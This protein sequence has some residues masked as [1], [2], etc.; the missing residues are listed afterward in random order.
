MRAFY[1]EFREHA[2]D[3]AVKD[4]DE[5]N[6]FCEEKRLTRKHGNVEFVTS[7]KYIH[8]Y[9]EE[10]SKDAKILILPFLIPTKK[11]SHFI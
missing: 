6:K 1:R 9:L 7:M 2:Y 4:S 10:M 3:E 5:Y 8:K 11:L